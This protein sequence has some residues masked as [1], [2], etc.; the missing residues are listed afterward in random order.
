MIEI[1]QAIILGI[2][3]G[4]SEFLPIS[5]S[6]HL[7]LI[8]KILGWGGVINSVT[9]DVALHLGTTI[10]LIAFFWRDWLTITIAF[11]KSLRKGFSNVWQD[12]HARLFV[13]LALASVPGAVIGK[14]FEKFF[15]TQVRNVPLVAFALIT[16]AILLFLADR[17]GKKKRNL[18][19]IQWVDAVSI[20]L[21]QT[22]ALVPGVSRSGVTITSGLFR[23]FDRE[24]AVRFSFL[25]SAPLTAGAILDKGNNIISGSVN[26]DTQ[27]IFIAGTL[28]AAISG[29]LAIKLLL[30]F[31][32]S[33]NFNVFV[34]Y[35][36]LLGIAVLIAFIGI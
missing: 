16:F 8:P 17:I 13:L 21:A 2:V 35:R 15:E 1:I 18:E 4:A 14:L 32:Q 3:Q 5:S 27:G 12:K 9:F 19:S 6:G 20:G 25:L 30:K 31:V 23:N 24:S 29:F 22:L 28:T 11:F 36:I 33:N 26:H 7:F 34:I 10:A